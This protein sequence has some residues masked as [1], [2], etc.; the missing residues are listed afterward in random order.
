M[1][2]STTFLVEGTPWVGKEYG[3]TSLEEKAL[4]HI[5]QQYSAGWDSA[6]GLLQVSLGL[7]IRSILTPSCKWAVAPSVPPHSS[8]DTAPHSR[9]SLVPPH[10]RGTLVH[11]L[12]LR[13]SKQ[14]LN[15]PLWQCNT[16]LP[17]IG[18]SNPKPKMWKS[19]SDHSIWTLPSLDPLGCILLPAL[20]V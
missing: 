16:S 18:T 13:L 17:V 4:L 11:M 1:C 10:S 12:A 5:F 20:W 9:W 3:G 8:W 15:L 2:L 6:N 14:G 7:C 19:H